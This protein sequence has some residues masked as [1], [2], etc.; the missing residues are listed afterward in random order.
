MA[1]DAGDVNGAASS[2]VV[3]TNFNFDTL[4]ISQPGDL[5][6]EDWTRASHLAG[7]TRLDVD[8]ACTLSTLIMMDFSNLIDRQRP[9][10]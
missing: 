10:Q 1:V 6:F 9:C 3:V 5:P 4:P 2:D 7:T 8:G